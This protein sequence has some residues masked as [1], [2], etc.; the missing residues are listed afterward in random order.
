MKNAA[1]RIRVERELRASFADACRSE[2]RQ[3]SDVL[4][5]FMQTYAERHKG[6]QGDMFPSKARK[7]LRKRKSA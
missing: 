3:A 2:D 6:G 1:I 5:E 4:R 7:S